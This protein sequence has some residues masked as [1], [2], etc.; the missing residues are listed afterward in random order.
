[1]HPSERP[2]SRKQTKN[3][4]NPSRRAT[5]WLSV[6]IASRWCTTRRLY[7]FSNHL[8]G[9]PFISDFEHFY[10][11]PSSVK[12]DDQTT[13]K[14]LVQEGSWKAGRPRGAPPPI[15]PMSAEFG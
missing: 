3:H 1:M 13:R 7:Y 15:V 12:T 14:K 2:V 10:A 5:E 9:F 8:L 6:F 4:S 11:I